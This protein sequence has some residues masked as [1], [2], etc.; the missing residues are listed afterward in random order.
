VISLALPKT[1]SGVSWS[2]CQL[3][4]DNESLNFPLYLNGNVLG[5][6]NKPTF[7]LAIIDDLKKSLSQN[8][9][10]FSIPQK[11]RRVIIACNLKGA[12]A[13]DVFE[14]P[15]ADVKYTRLFMRSVDTNVVGLSKK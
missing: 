3:V 6:L 5:A 14:V 8:D 10:R 7:D 2:H 4:I 15:V 1:R 11:T 13:R 12:H 9:V